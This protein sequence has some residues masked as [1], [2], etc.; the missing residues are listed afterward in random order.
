MCA[1]AWLRNAVPSKT[2]AAVMG[3]STL[4]ITVMTSLAIF[5]VTEFTIDEVRCETPYTLVQI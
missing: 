4:L 5:V 1:I 3:A 2:R